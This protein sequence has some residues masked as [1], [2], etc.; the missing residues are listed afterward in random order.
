M[1]YKKDLG[2]FLALLALAWPALHLFRNSYT[3]T[4]VILAAIF[5]LLGV[6]LWKFVYFKNK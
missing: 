2:R 4:Q 6:R 1:K 3:P 5:S